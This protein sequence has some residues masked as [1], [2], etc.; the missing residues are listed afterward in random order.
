MRS[1]RG[2]MEISLG[3]FL[4]FVMCLGIFFVG[5]V[6][7]I[8]NHRDNTIVAK[9]QA[10]IDEAVQEIAVTGKLTQTMVDQYEESLNSLG[11]VWNLQITWQVKDDNPLVKSAKVTSADGTVYI[12]NY[13]TNVRDLL[14]DK[15]EIRPKTDDIITFEVTKES[16]SVADSFSGA[17]N[18]ETGKV[19]IKASA[20]VS[21]K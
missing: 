21:A 16:T 5:P 15:G 13:D 7:I 8:A 10:I 6:V 1:N 17:K 4:V 9:G 19:T 18:N 20:K 11:E 3:W 2:A 12:V 14:A